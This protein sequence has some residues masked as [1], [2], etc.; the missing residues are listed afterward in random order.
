MMRIIANAFALWRL[1]I[2]AAHGARHGYF[3]M[4]LLHAL[5]ARHQFIEAL[6]RAAKGARRPILESKRSEL[7]WYLPFVLFTYFYSHYQ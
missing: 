4:L 6:T 2:P 1:F 5:I 7:K 3:S